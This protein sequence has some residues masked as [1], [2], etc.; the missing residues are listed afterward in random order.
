LSYLRKIKIFCS[1]DDLWVGLDQIGHDQNSTAWYN[2]PDDVRTNDSNNQRT[3]TPVYD[4]NSRSYEQSEQNTSK[5]SP[6][7]WTY[8]SSNL[9][10]LDL[11]DV[12]NDNDQEDSQKSKS[13]ISN[14][15]SKSKLEASQNEN[16]CKICF[17]YLHEIIKFFIV[18]RKFDEKDHRMAVNRHC[19]H[20]MGESCWRKLNGRCAFCNKSFSATDIIRVFTL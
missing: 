5:I 15:K 12:E 10:M 17:E 3:G 7:K 4:W 8:K 19:G 6:E 20:M 2:L 1:V 13:Q 9:K 16:E 11:I 18:F 14:E